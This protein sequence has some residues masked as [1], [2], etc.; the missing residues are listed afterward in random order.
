MVLCKSVLHP[1]FVSCFRDKHIECIIVSVGVSLPVF[2]LCLV[3]RSPDA[4]LN[5]SNNLHQFIAREL[6][7]SANYV[8]LGDCNYLSIDWVQCTSQLPAAVDFLTCVMELGGTQ[9]VAEPTRGN[10]ILDLII[11][12]SERFVFSVK[13]IDCFANS[14]HAAISACINQLKPVQL[15]ATECTKLLFHKVDYNLLHDYCRAIDWSMIYSTFLPNDKWECFM[16]IIRNIVS[17][18]V[19]VKYISTGKRNLAP[20]S[21]SHLQ[22]LYYKKSVRGLNINVLCPVLILISI[23]WSQVCIRMHVLGLKGI[24]RPNCLLVY[25]LNPSH[26]LG[27]LTGERLALVAMLKL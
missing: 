14:D 4:D 3:Y 2:N 23:N 24:M 8:L 26:F 13:V 20:W 12:S 18:F 25:L 7:N 21:N 22:C 6:S 15:H 19:P 27:M 16:M 11:S 1:T 5:Q 10:A 9:H 17:T